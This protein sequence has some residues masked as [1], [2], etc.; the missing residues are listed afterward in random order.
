MV[1]RRYCSRQE[2]PIDIP[3]N[4]REIYKEQWKGLEDFLGGT[5][6]YIRV[7]KEYSEAKKYVKQLKLKST[8]QWREY[9]KSGKLPLDIPK[10][11]NQ[12][13]KDQWKGWPD[14]LGK[15]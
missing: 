10:R 12:K 7:Y 14:F 2:L 13:Y 11:P 9:C 4:P 6:K 5:S 1:W 15:E 3:K 8:V